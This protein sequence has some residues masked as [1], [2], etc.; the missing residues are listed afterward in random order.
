MKGIELPGEEKSNFPTGVIPSL[1]FVD[2]QLHFFSSFFM[3]HFL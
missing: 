2:F 1:G 3:I